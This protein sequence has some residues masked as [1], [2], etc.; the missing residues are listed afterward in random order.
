MEVCGGMNIAQ[1]IIEK[2]G[3]VAKTA[4]ICGCTH[5]WV[6]KWTY[7]KERGGRGG[8]VPHDDAEKILAAARR[9][10]CPDILPEDFFPTGGYSTADR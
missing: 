2:L 1:Q 4:T 5:S 3:G 9:G 6:Y 8:R 7:P 10:E